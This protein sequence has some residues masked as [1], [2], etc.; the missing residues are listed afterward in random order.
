MSISAYAESEFNLLIQQMEADN[1]PQS[2][3]KMQQKMHADILEVLDL[4]ETHGHSGFSIGM[5]FRVLKKVCMFTP[6]TPLTGQESEWMEVAENVWQNKRSPAVFRT[7][8]IT[9]D[10][11]SHV[12]VEP[13]GWTRTVGHLYPIDFPY[14]PG[15]RV[16]V[17]NMEILSAFVPAGY[18]KEIGTFAELDQVVALYEKYGIKVET[19]VE[20]S[21]ESLND[22]LQKTVNDN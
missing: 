17:P 4:M 10:M 6:L 15:T 8:K 14:T 12:L 16:Y 1:A 7:D 21:A 13:D 2:D 20:E 5:F 18:L 11:D 19:V 22:G 3:I 9:Y